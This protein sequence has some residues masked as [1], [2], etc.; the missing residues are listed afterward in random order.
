MTGETTTM[1]GTVLAIW[2][3]GACLFGLWASFPKRRR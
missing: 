1:L 2:T 3:V